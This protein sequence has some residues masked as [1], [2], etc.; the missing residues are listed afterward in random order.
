MPCVTTTATV[1]DTVRR[2][3]AA[4][5]TIRHYGWVMS[6][7]TNVQAYTECV[8]PLSLAS[9]SHTFV[10]TLN[11]T[12]VVR[13]C[14]SFCHSLSLC[15]SPWWSSE[16]DCHWS[17]H[18]PLSALIPL[19]IPFNFLVSCRIIDQWVYPCVCPGGLLAGFLCLTPRLLGLVS[20]LLVTQGFSVRPSIVPANFKVCALIFPADSLLCLYLLTYFNI[21]SA[22]DWKTRNWLS[23]RN[24]HAS[25]YLC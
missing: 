12:A 5:G 7:S 3:P 2:T 23:N 24:L 14:F 9:D 11:L 1:C 17:P 15:P 16:T 19:F 10:L 6:R 22:Y 20:C 25:H 21:H 18:P 8:C 4:G 13:L